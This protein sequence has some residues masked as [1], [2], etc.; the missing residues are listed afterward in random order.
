MSALDLN[1]VS[2]TV[3]VAMIQ[4]ETTI[5]PLRS[6]THMF[7]MRRTTVRRLE[8]SVEGETVFPYLDVM[9]GDLHDPTGN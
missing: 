5:A 7:L 3:D 1:H 8:R 9:K 2:A 6:A 4:E